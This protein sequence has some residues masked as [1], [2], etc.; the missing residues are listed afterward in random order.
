MPHDELHVLYVLT[1]LELGG[2]QKVCLALFDGLQER[3]VASRSEERRVGK[4]CRL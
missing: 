4:E 3:G 1:K 2:A